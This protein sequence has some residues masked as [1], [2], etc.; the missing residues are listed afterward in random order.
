MDDH[1]RI[2]VGDHQ[3]GIIGLKA[4]L[5]EAAHTLPQ[6]SDEEIGRFLVER[7]RKSNYIPSSA[8]AAYTEAFVREWRAF[9][10]K[11]LEDL[12]AA[13]PEILVVG[14]GCSMCDTLL[15]RVIRE[16]DRMGSPAAVEHVTDIKEIAKLGVVQVPALMING[17]IA[18]KGV[19]PDERKLRRI[20]E[21]AA[22]PK[23][24]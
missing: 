10:G 8:G 18:A 22:G 12:S 5:E 11:P 9:T 2:R 16:L 3:T 24:E 20:L 21:E 6:A 1:S 19:V 15:T 13:A 17:K 14:P 7:L 4:A 23:S